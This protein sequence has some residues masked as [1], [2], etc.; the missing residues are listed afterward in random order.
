MRILTAVSILALGLSLQ[1]AQAQ[2]RPLARAKPAEAVKTFSAEESAAM[3]DATREKAEA[4]AR[5][6]DKRLRKAT[7]GICTGC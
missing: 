5:A 4:A 6:R 7:S 2:E 3:A 1:A